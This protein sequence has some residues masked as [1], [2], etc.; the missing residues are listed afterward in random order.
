MDLVNCSLTKFSYW[1][2][3]QYYDKIIFGQ[4][5]A[6]FSVLLFFVGNN[7]PEVGE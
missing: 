3:L 5:I 1:F 4:F 6:L 2:F 7:L